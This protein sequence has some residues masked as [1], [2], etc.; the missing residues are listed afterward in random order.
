MSGCGKTGG[1]GHTKTKTP[2]SKAG[3]Q[4]LISYIH[5]LLRKGRYA[6][7]V[8]AGAPVYLAAVLEYLTVEI[9]ELA[10]NTTWD[11]KKTRI[12]PCHLKFAIRNDEVL[13]KLPGGVTIAQ[14][15]ALP[16]IQSVLLPKKTGHPCKVCA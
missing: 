7:H 11:N 8:G 6:E 5:W 12:I 15:G 4:F 3:L 10:G 2:S 9:L 1:K 16:K 13:N 14:R